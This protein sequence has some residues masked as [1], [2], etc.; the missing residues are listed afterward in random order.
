M[1]PTSSSGSL[2]ILI[3]ND[4]NF[5]RFL[6]YLQHKIHGINESIVRNVLNHLQNGSTI[7]FIVRYRQ[8]DI[9][10]TNSETCNLLKNEFTEFEHLIKLKSSRFNK[11]KSNEA[12]MKLSSEKFQQCVTVSELDEICNQYKETTSTKI[13]KAKEIPNL[14]EIAEALLTNRVV[15]QRFPSELDLDECHE[16]LQWYL[17]DLISHSEN[18][19]EIIKSLSLEKNLFLTVEEKKTKN[20]VPSSSAAASKETFERKK[21]QDYF[22]F[23]K[24]LRSVSHHQ[25]LAIRRGKETAEVLKTQ[26]T[27][28][29]QD[30]SRL[31]GAICRSYGVT[32]LPSNP[33]FSLSRRNDVITIC[34]NDAIKRILVPMVTRSGWRNAIQLAEEEATKIFCSNLK[35]LLLTPPL[36]SI[37]HTQA[38]GSLAVRS[39]PQNSQGALEL[40]AS[41]VRSGTLIVLGIDPG[42][43]Q[44]HK[45]NPS[46]LSLPPSLSV[47]FS[48]G[49]SARTIGCCHGLLC[50]SH[51]Q[52]ALSSEDRLC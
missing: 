34:V 14:V 9:G 37:L 8:H 33:H 30:L 36:R 4:P 31:R 25:I 15:T 29:E 40:L 22:Q 10:S 6:N 7:P 18:V 27:L 45:V 2:K 32:S 12:F 20:E 19:L 17:S 44:G 13:Q 39:A 43:K 3:Q 41:R 48:L 1:A 28:S 26:L 35:S 11:L 23:A 47:L 16:L 52:S 21:Y 49:P 46:P 5:P 50:W 42:F 38:T 24:T 51:S